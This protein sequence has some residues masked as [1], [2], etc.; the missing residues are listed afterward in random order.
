MNMNNNSASIVIIN[1]T[2][3]IN[4]LVRIL[5]FENSNVHSDHTSY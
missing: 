3:S 5:K 1:D 4:P 2:K